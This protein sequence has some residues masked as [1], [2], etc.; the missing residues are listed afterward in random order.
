M[1]ATSYWQN[2]V[3][4]IEYIEYVNKE[5]MH[6]AASHLLKS[7]LSVHKFLDHYEQ[8]HDP[9]PPKESGPRD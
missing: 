5:C 3:T 9:L 8:V 1:K 6:A 4:S 7:Q 2:Y